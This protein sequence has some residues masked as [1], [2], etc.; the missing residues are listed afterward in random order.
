MVF[1]WLLVPCD[2]CETRFRGKAK[3]YKVK[4]PGSFFKKT[5]CARCNR[6]IVNKA[7][8]EKFDAFFN[9]T[10]DKDPE[11]VQRS[12]SVSSKTKQ[13]VW[14]RDDGRCVE[15]GSN[16]LLEYDHIVPFSKGGSNTERNIQ[17]L[18]EKCNRSK[19]NNIK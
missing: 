4:I 15:C 5:I 11:R 13:A 3:R 6:K 14:R 2:I 8:D 16:E 18:C 1:D 10:S 12:R 17:L 19:S 7:S 9:K